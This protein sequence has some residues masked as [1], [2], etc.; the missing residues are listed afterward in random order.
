MYTDFDKLQHELKKCFRIITTNLNSEKIGSKSEMNLCDDDIIR[1]MR[2]RLSSYTNWRQS[3]N[4][5]IHKFSISINYN[6]F[7]HGINPRMIIEKHNIL[8]RLWGPLSATSSYHVASTFATS[9]GMILEINSQ[10]PKL[11]LCYAFDASQLSDYPEESER[12]VGFMYVRVRKI[13]AKSPSNIP[14]SIPIITPENDYKYDHE[15]KN[16][17]NNNNSSS[18]YNLYKYMFELSNAH[19]IKLHFFVMRLFLEG[20]IQWI[21]FWRRCIY[22]Y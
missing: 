6:K 5:T 15:Y 14:S 9:R 17:N 20:F 19:L 11:S 21:H 22:K 18:G 12:L 7:Y 1:E 4:I 8:S 13:F 16:N 10:Y 2:R 3:L